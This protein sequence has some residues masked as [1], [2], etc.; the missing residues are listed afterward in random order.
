MSALVSVVIPVRDERAVIAA[1]LSMIE[2][3]TWW[4]GGPPYQVIV[5]DGMSSDGTRE[6]LERAAATRP[7][8]S[9]LDNPRR[10][11]PCALNIGLAAATGDLFARIDAHAEY[12]PDYLA[13]LAG[14]LSARDDLVGAGGAMSTAGR[15]PWG[16]AIAATLGRPIGLGGARHRVGGAAGPIEHVFTGMYRTAA[17]RAIGGWDEQMPANEDF[18]ADTRLRKAGG[19]LWLEPRATSTWFTR[20][21]PRALGYQMWRYGLFKGRTLHLHPDSLKLRQLAPPALVVGVPLLTLVR[22]RLGALVAG[23]Y[24]GLASGAGARAAALDGA[25]PLRGAAVP[26]IVH[27]SWGSGVTTGLARGLVSRPRRWGPRG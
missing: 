7:W 20:E 5:V 15:G 14:L 19:T 2:G 6:F 9:L 16:R 24:L 25:S 27:L 11:V 13:V 26:A 3:Q 1:V 12:S 21:D 17:L 10:I 22:P 4:E 8:L 18:E 23:G